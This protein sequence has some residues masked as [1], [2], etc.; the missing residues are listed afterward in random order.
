[1]GIITTGPIDTTT[2]SL[3]MPKWVMS[4]ISTATEI[5]T[6]STST[7]RS[8]IFFGSGHT[9]HICCLKEVKVDR[10][11]CTQIFTNHGFL[12]VHPFDHPFC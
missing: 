3:M 10:C 4:R 7:R 11:T 8:I 12:E 9:Q 5:T 2:P 6:T 1:M